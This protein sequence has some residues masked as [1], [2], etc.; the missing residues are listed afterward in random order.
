M[1]DALKILKRARSLIAEGWCQGVSA[2]D[3]NGHCTSVDSVHA[4]KW[5]I[6]GAFCAS[7]G[8]GYLEAIK[9]LSRAFDSPQ[10]II[11]WNDT[12]G[13]TQAEVL[14]AFDRAIAAKEAS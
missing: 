5:C 1:T 2:Q 8:V 13:R 10:S 9:C 12:P 14:A 4:V 11:L 6:D 7:A 3:A